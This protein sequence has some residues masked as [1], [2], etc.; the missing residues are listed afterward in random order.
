MQKRG[1][2]VFWP[3]NPPRADIM[4]VEI[5]YKHFDTNLNEVLV[6]HVC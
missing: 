1:N 3:S 2:L 4:Y 6:G 5:F